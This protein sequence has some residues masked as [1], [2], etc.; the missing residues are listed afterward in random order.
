VGGA[1]R[2][3]TGSKRFHHPVV[4]DLELTYETMT[5]AADP[6]LMLFAYTAEPGSRSAEALDLLASWAA[7]PGEAGAERRP[8]HVPKSNRD[9]RGRRRPDTPSR[10]SRRGPDGQR[11]VGRVSDAGTKVRSD[12]V[13]E[14]FNRPVVLLSRRGA[15]RLRLLHPASERRRSGRCVGPRLLGSSRRGPARR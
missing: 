10:R 12:F 2:P 9:S 8:H 13:G 6:S 7:T 1:Q 11:L 3:D 14:R 4:G 15:R 5:L